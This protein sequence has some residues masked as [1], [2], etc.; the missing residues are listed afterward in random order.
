MDL[1]R[2]GV[3]CSFGDVLGNLLARSYA[4]SIGFD[5]IVG[6]VSQISGLLGSYVMWDITYVLLVLLF[7]G[8]PCCHSCKDKL[9]YYK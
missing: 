9:Y 5:V 4:A 2:G 6:S 3:A 7:V 8:D 1:L